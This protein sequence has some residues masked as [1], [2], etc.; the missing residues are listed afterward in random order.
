MPDPLS[1]GMN[2]APKELFPEDAVQTCEAE[3]QAQQVQ[4][5]MAA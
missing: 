5:L 2:E 4:C 3:A 1:L